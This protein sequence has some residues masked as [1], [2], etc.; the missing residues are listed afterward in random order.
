LPRRHRH[1]FNQQVPV[2]HR[3]YVCVPS[4]A[5][6]ESA[7]YYW[8]KADVGRPAILGGTKVIVYIWGNLTIDNFTPR[9]GKDTIG[10]PGQQA[11][12]SASDAILTG[13]KA[14][15]IEID[16]LKPPLK[17]I[18]DDPEQG[19]T[20]GHFAIAPV[21]KKGDVDTKQLEAWANSRGTGQTHKFTQILLNA[22]VEPNVK[23]RTQ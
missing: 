11:G 3:R 21:D 8:G 20:P 4:K 7:C 23:G 1:R 22:V 18:P 5:I 10:R 9:P 19:G 16:R 17:A 15:G 13:R 14:Q 6:A 12:L 2:L